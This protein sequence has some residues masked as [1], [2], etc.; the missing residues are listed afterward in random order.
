MAEI[1][2]QTRR[3]MAGR[4]VAKC[5]TG[6]ECSRSR[7]IRDVK[8]PSHVLPRSLGLALQ[9]SRHSARRHYV[10]LTLRPFAVWV[11]ILALAFV[12][13]GVREA[14]L[15]KQLPRP[16]AFVVSGLLLMA[17]ILAISIWLIPWAGV[18]SLRQ[19]VTVGATWLA[20]TLVF[21][22]GL[23]LAQGKSFTAML[24]AYKFKEGNIWPLVLVTVAVAPAVG[25]YVRG[26][27]PAQGAP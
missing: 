3:G 7:E 24:D 22:F 21:E 5:F 19:C 14:I 4:Q 8:R 25:A 11:V 1:W 13:G 26:V 9:Q 6:G 17:C 16:T 27:L 12:N 23:G 2:R 20:L 10:V 18:R 15:F